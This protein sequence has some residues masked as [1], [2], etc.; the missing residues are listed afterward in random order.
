LTD[1]RLRGDLIEIYKIITG[2]K[3]IKK[4]DFLIS[5]TPVTTCEDTATN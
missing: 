4:E 2:K 3:K 1:R 5:V